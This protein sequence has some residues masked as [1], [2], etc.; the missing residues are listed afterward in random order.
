MEDTWFRL[1]TDRNLNITINQVESVNLSGA[2][3]RQRFFCKTRKLERR[4]LV[5]SVSN[6][7][8]PEY[9]SFIKI[10]LSRSDARTL[11]RSLPE[12][13]IMVLRL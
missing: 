10:Y 7:K 11:Y 4:E 5:N 6:L 2:V 12:H 13:V 3:S 8:I 1:Y 9:Y